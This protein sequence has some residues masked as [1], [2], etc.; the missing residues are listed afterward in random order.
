L[1]A[2][3]TPRIA[4]GMQVAVARKRAPTGIAWL[5]QERACARPAPRTPRRACRWRSP[6]SGLLRE[7]HAFR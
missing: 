1:R 7:S 6:A 4:A 3:G 2:T 5:S